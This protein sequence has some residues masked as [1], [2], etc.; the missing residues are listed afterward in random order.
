MR[1][2]GIGLQ[3]PLSIAKIDRYEEGKGDQ[4]EHLNWTENIVCNIVHQQYFLRERAGGEDE[5][6]GGFGSLVKPRTRRDRSPTR[7]EL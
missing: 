7:H 1:T 3:E 4:D 2:M 5:D 6:P